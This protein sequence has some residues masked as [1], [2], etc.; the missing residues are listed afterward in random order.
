M[1][2]AP[3]LIH[4]ISIPVTNTSVDPARSSGPALLVGGLALQLLWLFWLAPIAGGL[5][6]GFAYRALAGDPPAPPI[7]GEDMLGAD[8]SPGIGGS[9][10]MRA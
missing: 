3:T 2:A 5:I 6:G 8:Q 10:T 7:V 1:S 9:P 4:L